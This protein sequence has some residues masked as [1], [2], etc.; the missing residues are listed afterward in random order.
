[1]GCRYH[2]PRVVQT[3]ERRRGATCRRRS[4]T[5]LS[6][7]MHAVTCARSIDRRCS[8]AFCVRTARWTC[9]R[10][11][12]RTR[13][14]CRRMHPSCSRMLPVTRTFCIAGLA[15]ADHAPK[16]VCA[17]SKHDIHH[18]KLTR[19]SSPGMLSYARTPNPACVVA[20]LGSWER[21]RNPSYGWVAARDQCVITQGSGVCVG[22]SCARCTC[23]R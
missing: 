15:S 18:R 17:D 11:W 2:N 23:W 6:Q 9:L 8:S 19:F 13:R 12:T 22:P 1:M 5:R 10:R 16:Y 4:R 20:V 14:S 21:A 3:S 7:I